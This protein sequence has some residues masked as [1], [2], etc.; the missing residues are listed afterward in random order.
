MAERQGPGE[1]EVI[2]WDR[3]CEAFHVDGSLR[4]IYV[5]GTN[6]SDWDRFLDLVRSSTWSW[7]Y[8]ADASSD[9]LPESAEQVFADTDR[10]KALHV[11]LGSIQVAC[12]FFVPEEIELDIDPREVQSQEAMDRVLSFVLRLGRCL[13]KE[14]VLTEENSADWVWFRYGPGSDAITFAAPERKRS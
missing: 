6:T 10:A 11:D 3:C 9:L 4:D 5:F 7:S 12:H 1:G 2:S 13:E 8:A 14:V